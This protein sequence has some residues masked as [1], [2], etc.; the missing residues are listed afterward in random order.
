MPTGRYPR[1]WSIG[2]RVVFPSDPIS[3]ESA[4]PDTPLM[5]METGP[6]GVPSSPLTSTATG[7]VAG[8]ATVSG[9][10]EMATE[11][12]AAWADVAV[13]VI[14]A[15]TATEVAAINAVRRRR[16]IKPS[17]KKR[18]AESTRP[19]KVPIS[20]KSVQVETQSGER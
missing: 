3:L 17:S 19:S 1:F 10:D 8:K 16:K 11:R 7:G 2:K 13:R 18:R 5:V 14:P 12:P 9:A 4:M 6:E 20:T 15:T